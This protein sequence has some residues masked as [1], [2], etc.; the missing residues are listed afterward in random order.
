[1]FWDTIESFDKEGFASVSLLTGSGTQMQRYGL[2]NEHGQLHVEPIW[3]GI[4]PVRKEPPA[5]VDLQEP[6]YTVFDSQ[7]WCHVEGESGHGWINRNGLVV[8]PLQ[9]KHASGFTDFQDGMESLACVRDEFGFGFMNRRGELAIP[10]RF[11]AARPF[12]SYGMAAVG[13]G[14]AENPKWG[15]INRSGEF[16]IRPEWDN[17]QRFAPNGLAA[18]CRNRCWGCID[19]EGRVRIEPTWYSISVWNAMCN[20]PWRNDGIHAVSY[21]PDQWLILDKNGCEIQNLG[22]PPKCSS[23]LFDPATC[24]GYQ[25]GFFRFYYNV[26]RTGRFLHKTAMKLPVGIRGIAKRMTAPLNR[27]SL[28]YDFLDNSGVTIWTSTRNQDRR[29]RAILSSVAGGLCLVW[30]FSRSRCGS[31][32]GQNLCVRLQGRERP[33][34]GS[35]IAGCCAWHDAS[36]LPSSGT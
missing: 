1:M 13:V 16:V 3:R 2:I 12:D 8:S 33:A 23:Y 21:S 32:L 6:E 25:F 5:G 17:S 29:R 4:Y 7:G 26:N 22:L 11:C 35:D 15:W 9:W 14:D 20:Q 27:F 30:T 19:R 10:G 31:A 18:V 34:T 24:E 28:E 36:F